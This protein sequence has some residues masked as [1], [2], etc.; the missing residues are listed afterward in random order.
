MAASSPKIL[1]L[2]H[3]ENTCSWRGTC[4]SLSSVSLTT[5]DAGELTVHG[6]DS[7]AE[8]DESTY[9]VDPISKGTVIATNGK[10]IL[11]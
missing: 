6:P 11:Y 3:S 7:E 2:E 9:D 8:S 4:G 5:Y 1:S 10:Q